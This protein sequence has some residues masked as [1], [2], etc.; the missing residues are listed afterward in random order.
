MVSKSFG[1][2][3][4]FVWQL[5]VSFCKPAAAALQGEGLLLIL[6]LHSP[7]GGEFEFQ[8]VRPEA[9]SPRN[10]VTVPRHRTSVTM[11]AF[12]TYVLKTS[13]QNHY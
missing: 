11:S 1:H 2:S 3:Y 13:H 9:N 8:V 7:S 5:V 6:L 10:L 12:N 4:A